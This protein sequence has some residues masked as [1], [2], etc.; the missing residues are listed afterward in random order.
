MM[1]LAA[2]TL[3]TFLALFADTPENEKNPTLPSG[4]MPAVDLPIF[5]VKGAANSPCMHCAMS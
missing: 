3:T 5:K 4:P 2:L 1:S